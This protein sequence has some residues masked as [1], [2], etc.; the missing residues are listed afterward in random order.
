MSCDRD[1]RRVPA[2]PP[3][4][5]DDMVAMRT[6]DLQRAIVAMGEDFGELGPQLEQLRRPGELQAAVRPVLREAFPLLLWLVV[7]AS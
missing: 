6:F 4:E 7:A 1:D 3:R 2:A 5:R